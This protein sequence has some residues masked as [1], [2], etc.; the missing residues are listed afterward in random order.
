MGG[1]VGYWGF[2]WRIKANARPTNRQDRTTMRTKQRSRKMK[3]HPKRV[4]SKYS[5]NSKPPARRGGGNVR[6]VFGEMA[7]KA[8]ITTLSRF[9]Q[10]HRTGRFG[11]AIHAGQKTWERRHGFQRDLLEGRARP[12][13]VHGFK[14][15]LGR[16]A[17][18]GLEAECWALLPR[19]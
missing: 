9:V 1:L 2:F 12:A 5:T 16:L 19:G 6:R 18:Q 3:G 13:S 17:S 11:V 14:R 15:V 8:R 4:T 7:L 10:P